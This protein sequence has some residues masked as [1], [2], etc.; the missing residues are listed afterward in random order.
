MSEPYPGHGSVRA[1]P[2]ARA[3]DSR[4]QQLVAWCTRRIHRTR[5]MVASSCRWRGGVTCD[6]QFVARVTTDQI[7]HPVLTSDTQRKCRRPGDRLLLYTQSMTQ[8]PSSL[9]LS[10][11]LS[12]THLSFICSPHPH[13]RSPPRWS[14][15]SAACT[16]CCQPSV[17]FEAPFPG[18]A[19]PDFA[20]SGLSGDWS[21]SDSVA[22]THKST[23]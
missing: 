4:S 2:A 14:N 8:Q 9:F 20:V 23:G 1:N 22:T 19:P 21:S 15:W 3:D 7:L 16:C 12:Y 10:L 6:G 11:I 5:S 13:R 17:T 18:L